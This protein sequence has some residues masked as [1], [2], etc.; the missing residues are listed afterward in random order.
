MTYTTTDQLAGQVGTTH[1]GTYAGEF[2][3]Q[4]YE[5]FEKEGEEFTSES[6]GDFMY[7]PSTDKLYAVKADGAITEHGASAVYQ[8]IEK[9][10]YL[11]IWE[12]ASDKNVE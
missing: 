1:A 5:I 6:W 12:A 10:E 4:A 11:E 2:Q 8:E 3:D 7:N 9:D